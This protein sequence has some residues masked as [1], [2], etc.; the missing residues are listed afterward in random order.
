MYRTWKM[1][2]G[3]G[4]YVDLMKQYPLVT[5][6][7]LKLDAGS[8]KVMRAALHF[9]FAFYSNNNSS[10]NSD[11]TFPVQGLTA[12]FCLCLRITVNLTTAFQP[13]AWCVCP[14]KNNFSNL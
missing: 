11:D 4:P 8:Q 5:D 2:C 9:P 6:V 1:D 10:S 3:Y 7:F 13:G 12:Y 14:F